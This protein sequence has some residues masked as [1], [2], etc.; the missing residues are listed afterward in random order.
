MVAKLVSLEGHPVLAIPYRSRKRQR[1]MS[2]PLCVLRW[3][4]AQGAAEVIV[5]HDHEGRAWSMPL[6]KVMQGQPLVEE[7]GLP[8][9][10]WTLEDMEELPECPTWPYATRQVILGPLPHERP[11]QLAFLREVAQ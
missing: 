3:A 4:E 10:A 9:R 6:A 5:R 8:E 1:A 2:L 11:R 7:P